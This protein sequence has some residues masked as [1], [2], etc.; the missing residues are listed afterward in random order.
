M[1]I[2]SLYLIFCLKK[3]T[4][5]KFGFSFCEKLSCIFNNFVLS[6]KT[7]RNEKYLPFGVKF[8]H[9]DAPEVKPRATTAAQNRSRR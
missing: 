3:F 2:V 6:L 7:Y 9:W 5:K 8:S 1:Q 4:S